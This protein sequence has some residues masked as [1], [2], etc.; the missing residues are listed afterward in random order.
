ML[1]GFSEPSPVT[2]KRF[3]SPSNAIPAKSGTTPLVGP[4]ITVTSP[5]K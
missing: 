1:S 3:P 5:V 4:S 2:P